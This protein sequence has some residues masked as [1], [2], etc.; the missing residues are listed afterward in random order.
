MPSDTRSSRRAFLGSAAAAGVGVAAL[1]ITLDGRARLEWC[2]RPV[3]PLAAKRCWLV[4]GALPAG[5][6]AEVSLIVRGPGLEQTVDRRVVR[7]SDELVACDLRLAFAHA[8]LVPGRYEYVAEAR[9]GEHRLVSQP[10]AYTL[11]PFTFGV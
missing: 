3:H 4:R 7:L 6:Q 5:A 2:R 1:G 10:V 9:V 8:E 11:R